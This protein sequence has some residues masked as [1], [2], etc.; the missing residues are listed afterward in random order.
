MYILWRTEKLMTLIQHAL[1]CKSH[2]RICFGSS[3]CLH[4]QLPSSHVILQIHFTKTFYP[5]V[6][7]KW[8]NW[9]KIYKPACSMCPISQVLSCHRRF[10]SWIPD[11]DTK[12]YFTR[13]KNMYCN[14]DVYQW[15]VEKKF[16]SEFFLV[17]RILKK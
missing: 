16:F 5:W 8:P 11:D 10:L 6:S 4:N 17:Y 9:L 15:G 12:I 1:P 7:K 13:K 2:A 3:T 14:S